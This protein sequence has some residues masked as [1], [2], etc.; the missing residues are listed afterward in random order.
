MN[1]LPWSVDYIVTSRCGMACPVCW[2]DDMPPHE[3]LPAGEQLAMLDRL[4]A[5]GVRKVVFTGGEPLLEPLLPQ[6]LERAKR[7]GLV[8][9]L[10]TNCMALASRA[11]QVM[12]HVAEISVSLDG[13]D[14]RRNAVNRRPGH[15]MATMQALE[16]LK[17]H[18]YPTR[19]VQVLTV[20]TTRNAGDL[21]ELGQLLAGVAPG[22]DAFTW[23]L[24]FC[25][26]I[27]RC[28]RSLVMDYDLFA[29]LAR[30]TQRHFAGRLKVKYSPQNHDNAYL[31]LLADGNLYT[32]VG[33]QYVL[34]GNLFRPESY[35]LAAFAEVEANINRRAPEP[36]H[37]R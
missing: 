25:Q 27:G 23:K 35:D 17:A 29:D 1:T 4:A 13:P 6:L 32:T 9:L 14:E 22:L 12:P 30:K 24:N 5:A 7:N 8:T 15:F 19:K 20:V 2:G 26:P 10:F 34:R 31:F 21:A 33:G 11:D 18:R 37:G 36:N 3:P 28:D 16:M